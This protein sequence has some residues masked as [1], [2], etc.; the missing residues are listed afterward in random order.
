MARELDSL[1]QVK[2]PLHGLPFCVK[3]DTAV[4]GMDSTVG[5]ARNLNKP[6]ASNATIVQVLEDLGGIPFCRTNLP[7]SCISYGGH[8]PIFGWITNPLNP[9]LTTGGS[10]SGKWTLYG[11]LD[12]D[13]YIN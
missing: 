6:W 7:Q 10:S 1:A 4:A 12:L 13:E 2:G 9:K 8:N 11:L 5:Y 3:D